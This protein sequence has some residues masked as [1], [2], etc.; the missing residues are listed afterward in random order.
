VTCKCCRNIYNLFEAFIFTGK[1]ALLVDIADSLTTQIK[2]FY[3]WDE[4]S[5]LFEKL[6][7]ND[8][9]QSIFN[10]KSWFYAWLSLSKVNVALVTFRHKQ[11]LIGFAFL[12]KQTAWYGD[13]YYLN[14]AGICQYDQM[15]IEHND[16]ICSEEWRIS[17]RKSLL[18]TLSQ[19]K[20]FHRLVI[21]LCPS[22][23]WR[24]QQTFLWSCDKDQVAYVDLSRLEK[25]KNIGLLLSKNTRSNIAR[26]KNYIQKKHGNISFEAVNNQIEALRDELAPLHIAQWSESDSGS[27][28]TN[29]YFVS[30]HEKLCTKHSEHFRTEILHFKAG[31]Q[32]LGFL[33]MLLSHKTIYFYLSAINYED[34]DN[35]Y[36][37]GLIMHKIAIEHYAALGYKR[38]DFLAG[39]ARYKESLST[40]HYPL[41]TLNIAN[42]A[43]KHRLL[44]GANRL[45]KKLFQI[46]GNTA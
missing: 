26:S 45:L 17:C 20:N 43:L 9:K 35:R 34:K 12:G 37:P 4:V 1:A 29:P 6:S 24:N 42:N 27:G 25:E 36:K 46:K 33:Y 41:Y 16:I 8:H 28:F 11:D 22:N 3:S 14:Q 40:D 38:Y 2:Q 32:D 10:S 23:E 19:I 44:F 5:E 31:E 18:D 15:W 39:Y 21:S 7:I 13:T 30:F